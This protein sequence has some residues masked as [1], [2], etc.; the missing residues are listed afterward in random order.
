LGLFSIGVD[1]GGTN[2]RV[3]AF[4]NAKG[5]IDVIQIP[6]RRLE[7]RDTVISDLCEA[8]ESLQLRVGTCERLVGLGVATPG[9]MELPEGRLLDLPNLPG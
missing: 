8:V 2:L 6:T 3:A 4:T 7:G 5:L 1:L 9:P